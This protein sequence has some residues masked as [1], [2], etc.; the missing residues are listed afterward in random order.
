MFAAAFTLWRHF[1]IKNKYITLSWNAIFHTTTPP[2]SA[3]IHF[4]MHFHFYLWIYNSIVALCKCNKFDLILIIHMYTLRSI[5]ITF[6]WNAILHI[7]T[8]LLP[9]PI[10]FYMHFYFYI[11]DYITQFVALR[12]C[13][14][15]NLKLI[16]H[17]YTLRWV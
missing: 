8:P 3:P 1:Y 13:N 4:Y 9:P 2:P 6:S 10:H 5:Y 17:M 15:F 16:I 14:K 12:K 11:Y 7:R